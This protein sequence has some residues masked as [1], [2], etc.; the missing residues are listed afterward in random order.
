M[1]KLDKRN[2][3]ANLGQLT[4]LNNLF[5]ILTVL[6]LQSGSFSYFLTDLYKEMGFYYFFFISIVF[7]CVSF[8]YRVMQ[9]VNL[10]AKHYRHEE[11]RSR[12][13]VFVCKT[14][15]IFPCICFTLLALRSSP[16]SL[17]FSELDTKL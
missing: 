14:C 8:S 1:H 2:N 5:K 4:S 9:I 3:S 7:L 16:S 15:N 11:K 13:A 12:N 10:T 6:S 17:A